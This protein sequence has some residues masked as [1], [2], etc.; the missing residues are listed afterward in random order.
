MTLADRAH[1][2]IRR[3]I[4]TG[5]LAPG[6]PLRMAMLS[7]RYDMGMS[8]LREALNRLQSEGLVDAVALKGFTVATLSAQDLNDTTQARILV[9]SEALRMA[10]RQGDDTW[11]T[12]IVAALHALSLQSARA[13]QGQAGDAE[14]LEQRHH[15]FHQALIAGCGSRWLMN[16]FEKLYAEAERYRYHSL[17]GRYSRARRDIDAE[18]SAIAEAALARDADR[19]CALLADHYRRT[20][21][22][23]LAHFADPATRAEPLHA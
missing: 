7:E 18:H 14:R 6:Q 23:I 9:E 8:P 22:M 19:A 16:F 17:S 5:A 3:D 12:G 1:D 20:Q 11:E 13:A 4:V 10:I 15:A 2:A 21:A